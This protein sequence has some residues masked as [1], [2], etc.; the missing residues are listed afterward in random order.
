MAQLFS[1]NFYTTVA[2]T[3]DSTTTSI[4]LTDA[5]GMNSPTG[6]D[7]ELVTLYDKTDY[8]IVKVTARASNVLT[9]VR[10][11]EGTTGLNYVANDIAFAGVTAETLEILQV[12]SNVD[13]SLFRIYDEGD[14][15]K[16]VAFQASGITT[17]TTRT[18]T[19][20][21]ADGT[22]LTDTD[23]GVTVQDYDAELEAISGLTSEANK[24]IEFTG[25]GTA[26]VIDHVAVKSIESILLVI[27]DE[28]TALTT[29]IAKLAFR[30]P[31]A[32]ILSE[33]RASVTT[34]PTDATLIV[35]I[36]EAGTSVLSTLLTIDSTDKTSTVATLQAVISDAALADDAE[37][38]IDVDQVGLTIA[39]AG[40]KV[41]LI[42]TRA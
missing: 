35:D 25:I 20:P 41:T 4:T 33:V 37:I 17:A 9:V 7:Y 26:Q 15:T 39:G 18:M 28:T 32:F 1:N 40:L 19:V 8:E 12:V 21:D 24:L 5:S 13:D 22:L 34:A 14:D 29:G 10:A 16:I 42:G 27:G 6:G 36:N 31:Y 11:Q 2:G 30:M 38:T 23:L 3:T